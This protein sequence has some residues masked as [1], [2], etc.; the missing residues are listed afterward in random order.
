M[1]E[2]AGTDHGDRTRG[3]PRSPDGAA[4]PPA[5][6]PYSSA[7]YSPGSHS[8]TPYSPAPYSPAPSAPAPYGGYAPHPYAAPP[9]NGAAT[10][11]LVC[12]ILGVF[13]F[14]LLSVPGAVLGHV[15]LRAARQ[16]RGSGHG[17]AVAGLVISYV[18]IVPGVL[19]V[20]GWVLIAV[21]G[22]GLLGVVGTAAS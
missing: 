21:L 9:S 4:R 22:V 18:V 6:A 19:F 7:P 12:A 13:S 8:S 14:G 3:L 20:L 16:R 11:S 1:T 5:P 17:L 2:P 10:A 15:G